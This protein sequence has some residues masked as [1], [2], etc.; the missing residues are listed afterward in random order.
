MRQKK[1]G[2]EMQCMEGKSYGRLRKLHCY[3][4][5]FQ[6]KWITFFDDGSWIQSLQECTDTYSAIQVSS[7]LPFSVSLLILFSLQL[8][9]WLHCRY[10]TWNLNGDA[11]DY[12]YAAEDFSNV[13]YSSLVTKLLALYINNYLIGEEMSC[14][15]IGMKVLFFGFIF[16]FLPPY[17]KAK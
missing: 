8:R 17:T 10:T 12:A 13:I 5:S 15:V 16:F 9:Y 3:C 2:M 7:F 4:V 11:I 6:L 1:W 14:H